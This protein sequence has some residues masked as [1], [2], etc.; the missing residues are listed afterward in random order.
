MGSKH[1]FISVPTRE[2]FKGI[3]AAGHFYAHGKTGPHLVT[4][5][6]FSKLKAN[7]RVAVELATEEEIEA[8]G[9]VAPQTSAPT[10][11]AD[12]LELLES[13]R[14]AKAQGVQ[15][16]LVRLAELD[17]AHSRAA[18]LEGEVKKVG[19]KVTEF[20]ALMKA[21]ASELEASRTRITELE[22][23]LK[24]AHDSKKK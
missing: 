7:P 5:D 14:S 2:G 22:Q 4:E 18:E 23:Q 9:P 3:F 16:T 20:D 8:G 21:R 17:Q 13:F 11:P 6:E 10:L 15:V 1:V 24:A 19:A 12:E